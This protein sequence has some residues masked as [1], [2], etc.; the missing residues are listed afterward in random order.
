MTAVFHCVGETLERPDSAQAICKII[1]SSVIDESYSLLQ[2]GVQPDLVTNHFL[3][4]EPKGVQLGSLA[5]HHV[6][7]ERKSTYTPCR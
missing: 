1:G 6:E 5:I 3:A 7:N 4:F 2:I